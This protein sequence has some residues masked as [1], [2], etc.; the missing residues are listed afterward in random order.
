MSQLIGTGQNQVPV[1]GLLGT[2]AFQDRKAVNIVGGAADNV[3]LGA[4]TPAAATITNLAYTGTLT[5]ATGVVNLGSGQVYKDASGNVGIG[6]SSPAYKLDVNGAINASDVIRLTY[7]GGANSYFLQNA[8]TVGAGNAALAFVQAGVAERMRINSSG[9]LGVGVTPSAWGSNYKAIQLPGGAIDSYTSNS[10]SVICNA[11]DSGAGAWTYVTSSFAT[12]YDQNASGQ[13]VWWNAA[14]GTAGA[15]ITFVNSMTL[16]ATS[17]LTVAGTISPQQATT[18]AAPAYVKG[19]M[20]FDTTLN[21][22]RIGGAT[23]WETVTSV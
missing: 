5:G 21:K 18:A 15:A 9:N 11:Y 14:T 13:H 23:A 12:R 4:T 6:T 22:L 16:S 3:V 7:P 20:Y 17:N 1:N 2:M 10:I 8:G 19:A